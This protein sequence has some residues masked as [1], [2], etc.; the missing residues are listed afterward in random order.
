GT[1]SR[2]SGSVRRAGRREGSSPLYDRKE[3]KDFLV[4]LRVALNPKDE[5]SFRRVINYPAQQIDETALEKLENAANVTHKSLFEVARDAGSVELAPDAVEGC[6]AFV[7][8]IERARV[9]L[10]K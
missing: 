10:A 4:Y 8:T 2:P 9:A 5:I 1:R 6:K 7:A 3:V